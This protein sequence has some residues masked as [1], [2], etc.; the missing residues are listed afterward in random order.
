[1]NQPDSSP[2][3]SKD[4]ASAPEL[5]IYLDGSIVPR[6]HARVSVFDAG[7]QSGDCVWEGIRA[8]RGRVF[9]L[10]AHLR[11]LFDSAKALD[12]TIHL[13]PEEIK[14]AIFST[15][16]AN[17]LFDNT[18]I[19]LIL[20]RG[21]RRTSGMNP[22]FVHGH[23]TLVIIAEHKP[24]IADERGIRLV[25]SSFRRPPPDCLNPQ[26]HHGNQLNSILA[27]IEANRAGVDGALLLDR[28]GFVAESDSAN[29]FA[30]NQ[31]ALGT[32]H[33]TAC[34]AG[35][36]R[37]LVIRLARSAGIPVEEK[38][39]SVADLY[40]ADEVFLTGTIGEIVPVIE[41]DGRQI[42]QGAPGP[43]TLRVSRLYRTLTQT[44]GAPI[45]QTIS[46]P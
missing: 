4:P 31:E 41:I 26:I 16:R 32:P 24:P 23:P 19:R 20:S 8:Y 18:H 43:M 42:G 44:E 35:I 22:R 33:P 2:R 27:K 46:A 9:E 36:T 10:D 29:L 1:M 15:L 3:G 37:G 34:L 40:A 5:F 39:L 13:G 30:A 38:D 12:I 28:N 14:E 21:E 45:D 17:R 11:R 25:T 6:S 7:F